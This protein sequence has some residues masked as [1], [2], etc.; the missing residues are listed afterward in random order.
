MSRAVWL[1]CILVAHR[2]RTGSYKGLS[3]AQMR[4]LLAAVSAGTSWTMTSPNAG[5]HSSSPVVWAVP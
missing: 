1:G 5:Y 3:D 2:Q 4:D